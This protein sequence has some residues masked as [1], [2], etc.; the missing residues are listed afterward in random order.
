[1]FFALNILQKYNAVLFFF[2]SLWN[3]ICIMKVSL[4]YYAV[5]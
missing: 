4:E 1:M 5:S 3:D 2:C